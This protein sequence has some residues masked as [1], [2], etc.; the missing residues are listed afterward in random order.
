MSALDA[1]GLDSA[2]ETLLG[3][4]DAREAASW[5]HQRRV[6]RHESQMEGDTARMVVTVAPSNDVDPP[7][8][9]QDHVERLRETAKTIRNLHETHWGTVGLALRSSRGEHP[10]L[11]VHRSGE[12]E[13]CQS[14]LIEE[15]A[16]VPL[17][18]L[19]PLI[20]SVEAARTLAIDANLRG[21]LYADVSLLGVQGS[22][23]HT[24]P[25]RVFHGAYGFDHDR[26]HHCWTVDRDG[27]RSDSAVQ[28]LADMLW[29]SGGFEECHYY[30]DEGRWVR[31]D[32]YFG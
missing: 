2:I 10:S 25:R 32:D 15:G 18:V 6:D 30:D 17:L 13:F 5:S 3:A 29:Q 22:Q 1:D 11:V 16:V 7:L 27:E 23:F 26:V 14:Y 28:P 20:G 9:L 19:I 31:W 8:D 4:V 12:V 24:P 21:P